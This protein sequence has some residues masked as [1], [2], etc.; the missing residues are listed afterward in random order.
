[1]IIPS[2]P[3]RW[4]EQQ[5]HL[6]RHFVKE[7]YKKVMKMNRLIAAL[8]IVG[9]CAISPVFAQTK[10]AA[11]P[12]PP[13]TQQ[14]PSNAPVPESKIALINSEFWAD[15]K[16]GIVRLVA[17]A[18]R[19]DAEFTPRRTELQQLQQKMT[20]LNDE[21]EKTKSVADPKTLQTKIDQLEA[22]KKEATRK[23]EDAQAAYQKRMQ[24]VLAPIYE[25]IGKALDAFGKARGITL[26]LDISK[27]GPAI[28]M[29]SDATDV[30]RAFIADFNSKFPAT[31]SVT[32]P[33]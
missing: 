28:L 20:T 2:Q 27:I 19:V 21:I 17:A 33:Q 23:Q 32:P 14:P 4:C 7:H 18:K 11:N 6:P 31:A 15:E 1:L 26:M 9:A 10:P 16:Q 12:A 30:T 8:A 25:D 3:L 13:A 5:S 24:D 29:A 22:W